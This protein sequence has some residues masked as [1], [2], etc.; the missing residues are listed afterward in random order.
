MTALKSNADRMQLA[1]AFVSANPGATMRTVIFH[2]LDSFDENKR[3]K[4]SA[5]KQA[6]SVVERIIKD[7]HVRQGTNLALYPW[8][9]KRKAYAEALERALFAAPTERDRCSIFALVRDAWRAAGD[10]A[11]VRV[12]DSLLEKSSVA[13]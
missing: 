3:E 4:P 2:V 6:A 9:V 12:L 1:I 13:P 7:R 10:E 11:R 8:D 5:Y